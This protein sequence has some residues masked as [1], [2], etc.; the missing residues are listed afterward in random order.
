[1]EAAD[2]CSFG[3]PPDKACPVADD[4]LGCIIGSERLHNPGQ[5]RCCEVDNANFYLHTVWGI[6]EY[7][8][9]P[10]NQREETVY[11]RQALGAM[12]ER[13]HIG[14]D[15]DQSMFIED[16]SLYIDNHDIGGPAP[17]FSQSQINDLLK[18]LHIMSG[19]RRIVDISTDDVL[20]LERELLQEKFTFF[21]H[22]A[23]ADNDNILYLADDTFVFFRN[24]EGYRLASIISKALTERN[25][26]ALTKVTIHIGTLDSRV[27]KHHIR[28]M[29]GAMRKSRFRGSIHVQ[30]MDGLFNENVQTEVTNVADQLGV[31]KTIT[32][33]EN[34]LE[35]RIE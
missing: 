34:E 21:M 5:P 27:N 4:V 15:Q 14:Q 7:G 28:M 29:K 3:C 18:L 8:N 16:D 12:L 33:S 30:G 20:R 6:L 23:P 10:G 31:T 2:F 25:P 17:N 22:D 32:T 11:I 9:A 26:F 35:I 1:M 24:I 19:E 13:L